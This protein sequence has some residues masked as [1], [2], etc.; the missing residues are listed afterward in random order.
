[1]V[2]I[3]GTTAKIVTNVPYFSDLQ[4]KQKIEESTVDPFEKMLDV[5]IKTRKLTFEKEVMDK[6]VRFAAGLVQ[7]M[8]YLF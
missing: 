7:D 5:Y 6:A 4:V 2:V 1:M 3:I 8:I